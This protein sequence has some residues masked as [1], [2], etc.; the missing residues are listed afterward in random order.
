MKKKIDRTNK[1][2]EGTGFDFARTLHALDQLGSAI[3]KNIQPS[4]HNAQKIKDEIDAYGRLSDSF[5]REELSE[6]QKSELR[7]V[8]EKYRDALKDIRRQLPSLI[9]AQAKEEK[10]NNDAFQEQR[11][12]VQQTAS[13]IPDLFRRLNTATTDVLNATTA[14]MDGKLQAFRNLRLELHEALRQLPATVERT[15]YF[16]KIDALNIDVRNHQEKVAKSLREMRAHVQQRAKANIQKVDDLVAENNGN[17]LPVFF[18]AAPE[19]V[20]QAVKKLTKNA[21]VMKALQENEQFLAL[22]GTDRVEE[23]LLQITSG[24]AENAIVPISQQNQLAALETLLDV[25]SQDKSITSKEVALA[26]QF[27]GTVVSLAKGAQALQN[28]EKEYLTL[29]TQKDSFVYVLNA[30]LYDLLNSP[31]TVGNIFST[32]LE[33]GVTQPLHMQFTS[34]KEAVTLAAVMNNMDAKALTGRMGSLSREELLSLTQGS[35][36]GALVKGSGGELAALTQAKTLPQISTLI[37]RSAGNIEALARVLGIASPK[38]EQQL[39]QV[40]SGLNSHFVGKPTTVRGPEATS[41]IMKAL[42]TMAFTAQDINAI[43]SLP[44]GAPQ[45]GAI[46]DFVASSFYPKVSLGNTVMLLDSSLQADPVGSQLMLGMVPTPLQLIN[47]PKQPPLAI[48][49]QPIVQNDVLVFNRVQSLEQQTHLAEQVAREAREQFAREK[50]ELMRKLAEKLVQV[51]ELHMDQ[52]KLLEKE[53]S[54]LKAQL[55][56]LTSTSQQTI[57]ELE[58]QVQLMTQEHAKESEKQLQQ[59]KNELEEITAEYDSE[60]MELQRRLEENGKT[61]EEMA[62]KF[63]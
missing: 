18:L 34:R 6:K 16:K 24:S 1:K 54:Q 35:M 5:S 21:K 45:R 13:K 8:R 47:G 38:L 4:Q 40:M 29:V 53:I 19:E 27:L 37:A 30:S 32:L 48:K 11:S 12:K 22:L 63:N 60:K 25:L 55:L 49:P 58:K 42:L 50:E 20:Q 17:L 43:I 59:M 46:G 44:K 2:T 57:T 31:E 39:T 26:R 61:M 15:D 23:G 56:S 3:S 9:E 7:K 10:K 36:S 62:T 14:T 33:Q 28:G 41:N 52:K 51:T